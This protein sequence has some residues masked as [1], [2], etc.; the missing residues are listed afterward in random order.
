MRFKKI[1][2]LIRQSGCLGQ[3]LRRNA[4]LYLTTIGI[5]RKPRQNQQNVNNF[6]YFSIHTLLWLLLVF[7]FVIK[8]QFSIVYRFGCLM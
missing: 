5:T 2:L 4:K 8:L 7:Q 1:L 6:P 3:T